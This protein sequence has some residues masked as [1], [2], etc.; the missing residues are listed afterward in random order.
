M[1]YYIVIIGPHLWEECETLEQAE[2]AK[3]EALRR[4]P[5]K[6]PR[7]QHI[8]DSADI[9]RAIDEATFLE[10]RGIPRMRDTDK[11]LINSAYNAL[12]VL[13]IAVER[14]EAHGESAS[15]ERDAMQ[16]LF[17]ALEA[18]ERRSLTKH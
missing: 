12:A 11:E 5:E 17:N 1:G 9:I 3:A 6:T 4:D 15:A 13:R 10:G 16:D 7:I 2:Q 8:K 14:I 18:V